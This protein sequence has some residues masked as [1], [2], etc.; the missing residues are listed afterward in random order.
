MHNETVKASIV[1]EFAEL[2]QWDLIPKGR[3]YNWNIE[4]Y[5]ICYISCLVGCMLLTKGID[6][7]DR[8]DLISWEACSE[9]I[10][11]LKTKKVM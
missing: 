6:A 11:A 4:F 7:I 3:L 5:T 1:N 2:Y 8:P 9:E 10:A